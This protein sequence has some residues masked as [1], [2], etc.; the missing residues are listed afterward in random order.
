MKYYKDNNNEIFALEAFYAPKSGWVEITE[1]EKDTIIAQKQQD[2][3]NALSYS[4]KRQ[5][6]YPP[7]T[8]VVYTFNT[9][10]TLPN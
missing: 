2:A 9:L 10:P 3:F 1:A 6:E 7:E 5:T 8:D 4:D